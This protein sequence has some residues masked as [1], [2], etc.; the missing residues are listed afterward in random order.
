[1][2]PLSEIELNPC[3]CGGRPSYIEDAVVNGLHISI[4]TCEKCGKTT[5][6]LL[7]FTAAMFWNEI[8]GH[9]APPRALMYNEWGVCKSDPVE[10]IVENHGK[11]NISIGIY[12]ESD[13]YFTSYSFSIGAVTKAAAAVITSPLYPTTRE[14]KH[15]AKEEIR[16]LCSVDRKTRKMFLDFGVIN[17]HQLDLFT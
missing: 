13:G 10:T 1:M 9:R 15:A 11:N 16:E 2:T 7:A 14:A 8:A 12:R 3:S 5:P 4:I 6:R 17:D